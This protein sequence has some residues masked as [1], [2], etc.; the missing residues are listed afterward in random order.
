MKIEEALERRRLEHR[1]LGAS[2]P[3]D[4]APTSS[5]EKYSDSDSGSSENACRLFDILSSRDWY[6]IIENML[7]T[8]L[9]SKLGMMIWRMRRSRFF[10]CE[11]FFKACWRKWIEELVSE[12]SFQYSKCSDTSF[13]YIQFSRWNS[14]RFFA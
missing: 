6:H 13:K 2:L 14:L 5:K 4:V 12:G 3:E 10:F 1:A 9:A 7:T 8:G 11:R